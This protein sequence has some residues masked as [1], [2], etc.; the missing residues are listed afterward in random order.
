[1]RR[2]H[3]HQGRRPTSPLRAPDLA[4]AGSHFPG[5]H[6]GGC[7]GPSRRTTGELASPSAGEPVA[8]AARASLCQQELHS[9]L[10]PTE[11]RAA[12]K[13]ASAPASPLE[14]GGVLR[15]ARTFQRHGSRR[16]G[17]TR[18]FLSCFSAQGWGQSRDNQP[19]LESESQQVAAIPTHNVKLTN[20][21][22]Q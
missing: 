10:L 18:G 12:L 20:K 15:R 3:C 8:T 6:T 22:G 1:M 16:C 7:E 2:L 9:P 17:H 5:I 21:T 11:G 14:A 4:T 19:A 13:T